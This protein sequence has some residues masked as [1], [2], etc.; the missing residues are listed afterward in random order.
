MKYVNSAFVIHLQLNTVNLV[1][2]KCA[3][4]IS[5]KVSKCLLSESKI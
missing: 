3:V 4:K 5:Q 1:Q 2:S